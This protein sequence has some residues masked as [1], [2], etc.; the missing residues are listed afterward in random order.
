MDEEFHAFVKTT[1]ML[2]TAIA[3]A[4]LLPLAVDGRAWRIVLLLTGGVIIAASYIE[5][6]ACHGRHCRRH[7]GLHAAAGKGG[8]HEAL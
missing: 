4:I 7:G 2:G 5:A 8:H 1:L 3:L 6:A